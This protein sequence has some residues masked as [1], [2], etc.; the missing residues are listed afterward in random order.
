MRRLIISFVF[1]LAAHAHAFA[2]DPP[3]PVQ[4]AYSERQLTAIEAAIGDSAAVIWQA[5]NQQSAEVKTKLVLGLETNRKKNG[6]VL[7]DGNKPL[8]GLLQQQYDKLKPGNPRPVVIHLFRSNS[9]QFNT[10]G[11][12]VYLDAATVRGLSGMAG[13]QLVLLGILAHEVSHEPADFARIQLFGS[14][15]FTPDLKKI[16]IQRLENRTDERA[17]KMLEDAGLDPAVMIRVVQM[18]IESNPNEATRLAARKGRIEEVIKARTVAT[19]GS[20]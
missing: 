7:L 18:L 15:N 3:G 12:D 5:A 20:R 11:D 14:Q 6:F 1:V 2:A 8:I 13:G 10:I 4:Q 19:A 9:E 17:V 16:L